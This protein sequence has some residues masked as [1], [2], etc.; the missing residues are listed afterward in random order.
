MGMR[1]KT[2]HR[3]KEGGRDS[4]AGETDKGGSYI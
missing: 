2:T 1:V 3:R 4:G